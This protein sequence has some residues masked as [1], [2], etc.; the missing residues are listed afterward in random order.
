MKAKKKSEVKLDIL[1]Q[2]REDIDTLNAT[3]NME[4]SPI[5]DI[6]IGYV[7]HKKRKPYPVMKFSWVD[8]GDPYSVV[9]Y[10]AVLRVT[11]LCEADEEDDNA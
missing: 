2:I 1:E 7:F 9:K 6:V 10:H 4:T 11:E 8:P 3:P 5:R